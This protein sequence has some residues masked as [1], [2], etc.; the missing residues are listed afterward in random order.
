ME[1]I[2]ASTGTPH[3][4]S[5]QMRDIYAGIFGNRD[6]VLDVGSRFSVTKISENLLRISDGVASLKG[7][8]T[9]IEYGKYEDVEIS[10][11]TIGKKRKDIICIRYACNANDG[12]NEHCDLVVFEG[13]ET[14]IT[15]GDEIIG[16]MN[17]G[18]IR[19]GAISYYYPIY[20]VYVKDL[21]IE[22]ITPLFK[23]AS[24]AFE[25]PWKPLTLGE[26][27]KNYESNKELSYK[28]SGKTVNIRGVVST[29][30]VL[31][32]N[33]VL[34]AY[35]IATIPEEISPEFPLYTVCH[36]SGVSKW[37]C[38]VNN[39]QILMQRH[40]KGDALADT[41]ANEWLTINICYLI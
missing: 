4:T 33:N 2:T 15:D 41:I 18:E 8:I 17:E 21:V 27:F 23:I 7:C 12:V 10:S 9:M 3:V 6:L 38:V 22:T 13:T 16:I 29:K 1:T 31:S 5:A 20:E 37:Q 24:I 19:E 11:G 36:G 40:S 28:V 32:F 39:N 30:D 34:D 26:D 25:T 35:I 14:D